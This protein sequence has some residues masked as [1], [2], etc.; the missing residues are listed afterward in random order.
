M[1]I[2]R[3][4]ISEVSGLLWAALLSLSWLMPNHFPP[5]A[6][7]HADA[8]ISFVAI[9]AA[10]VLFSTGK[11]SI[12]IH[13]LVVVFF[14][15]ALVPWLQF[16]MGVIA[17]AG[18]AWLTSLYILGFATSMLVGARWA[19]V[20]DTQPL[21]ALFLAVLIAAIASCGLAMGAWLGVINMGLDSTLSMGHAGARYYANLGQPNLLATFLEWGCISG[22]WFFIRKKIGETSLFLL[23]ILFCLCISLTGSRQ[24]YIGVFVALIITWIYR[25]VWTQSRLPWIVILCPMLIGMGVKFWTDLHLFLFPAELAIDLSRPME[26]DG[27]RMQIWKLFFHAATERPWFGYGWSEVTGAQ[28]AVARN[29]PSMGGLFGHTHNVMLDFVVWM[30]FPLAILMIAI[31]AAW[32][33]LCMIKVKSEQDVVI[34][35]A[36]GVFAVHAMLELP[37]Q[38][39]IFLFPVGVFIGVLNDRINIW[40]LFK[41]GRC[42]L[43]IFSTLL[44]LVLIGVVR[45]YLRVEDSYNR[46]RFEKKGFVYTGVEVKKVPDVLILTQF[47]HWF[48]TVAYPAVDNKKI[49]NYF[50]RSQ[51]VIAFPAPGAIFELGKSLA[52]E[53]RITEAQYWFDTICK[54]SSDGD[55]EYLKKVWLGLQIGNEKYRNVNFK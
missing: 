10:L 3:S 49:E 47:K 4:S 43:L 25:K 51:S 32:G 40:P 19:A 15:A 1:H 24:A 41:I 45:D 28:L 23:L 42:Y 44:F 48:E 27:I 52:D 54:V 34:L 35:L 22:L 46:F 5:W 39:A 53:G 36:L 16:S 31:L 17:F 9:G 11:K 50:I 37:H 14:V 6:S 12:E 8:W 55:C 30:G 38:Y 29:F 20:A 2:K 21:D 18:K 26:M 33:G 7:F 13:A